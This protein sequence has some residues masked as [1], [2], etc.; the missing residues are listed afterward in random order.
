MDGKLLIL[1]DEL[2]GKHNNGH[3]DYK[4]QDCKF[5]VSEICSPDDFNSDKIFMSWEAL[6][7][8]DRWFIEACK[9]YARLTE[10]PNLDFPL[11]KRGLS[12]PDKGTLKDSLQERCYYNVYKNNLEEL[13]DIYRRGEEWQG[14]ALDY[15]VQYPFDANQ[16]FYNELSRLLENMGVVRVLPCFATNTEPNISRYRADILNAWNDQNKLRRKRIDIELLP[17]EQYSDFDEIFYVKSTD[18][19]MKIMSLPDFGNGSDEQSYESTD[20]PEL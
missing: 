2:P 13:T 8:E 12:D 3:D 7:P 20:G 17:F 18:E 6:I 4:I 1:C 16:H 19:L 5:L 11:Q 14:L 10:K 15:A 9:Y